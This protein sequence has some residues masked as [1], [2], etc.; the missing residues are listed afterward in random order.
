MKTIHSAVLIVLLISTINAQNFDNHKVLTGN[1][2]SDAK[3]LSAGF[4]EPNNPQISLPVESK[5]SPILAGVLSFLVPGAGEIYTEEYLKA[6]I[7]LAIE[8]A[9]ITTAVIYDKKGNDKT[10]EFQNYADKNWSVNRYAEWTINSLQ[11]PESIIY[12]QNFNPL[13]YSVFNT[14]GSVNWSELNRLERSIGRGYSH[15]LPPYGEQQYYELIGKYPQYSAGWNDFNSNDYHDA[16]P[17][18]LFYAGERGKANDLY[19][20]ASKAVIGI[21]IN[22]FLSTLDAVWSATRFN[23][24]IAVKVRLENL[25]LTDHSE[26]IPTFYLTYSF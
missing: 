9:V 5:K 26:F 17:N 13:D 6:G 8:A 10:I 3:I 15:S 14:D 7:F 12:D 23:K 19:N 20:I 1:L 22:H 2:L 16:S 18:F 11:N 4:I 21:Y 25:Q 24:N